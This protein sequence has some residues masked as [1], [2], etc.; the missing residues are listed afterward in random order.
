MVF[1]VLNMFTDAMQ[2]YTANYIVLLKNH[3]LPSPF[4][5]KIYVF[6]E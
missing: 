5:K 4:L 1:I 6:A 2:Y 3:S